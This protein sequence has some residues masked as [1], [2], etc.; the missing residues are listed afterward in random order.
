[1]KMQCSNCYFWVFDNDFGADIEGRCH[2]HPPGFS[3]RWNFPI[4]I[5]TDWCGEYK[6]KEETNDFSLVTSL[7][8]EKGR[9][10]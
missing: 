5:D 7:E 3:Y 6:E 9:H 4:V 2:S 8:T 10:D 1:M